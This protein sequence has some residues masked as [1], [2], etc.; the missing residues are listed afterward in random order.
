MCGGAADP[1]PGTGDERD[2]RLQGLGPLAGIAVGVTVGAVGGLISQ[3]VARS[4]RRLPA[5]V[6]VPVLGATAMAL[7]DVPLKLLGISDPA[8]WAARDWASDAIPHLLYGAVT[9]SVLRAGEA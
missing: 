9:Y 7:S 5:V 1:A 4:G 6:A 2:N 3:A 8:S